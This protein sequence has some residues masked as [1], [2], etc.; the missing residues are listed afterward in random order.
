MR[1][2][3]TMAEASQRLSASIQSA[4]PEIPWRAIA[5]FRNIL[6][7]DY[8]GIDAE[9]IWRVVADELTPLGVALRRLEKTLP[10]TRSD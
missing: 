6:V 3:Q 4:A 1:N 5:G 7:H 9:V 2:L 8:L 10:Q